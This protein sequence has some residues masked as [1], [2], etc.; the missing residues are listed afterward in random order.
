MPRWNC[1]A[2]RACAVAEWIALSRPGC[3]CSGAAS[4]PPGTRLK[5]GPASLSGRPSM[6]LAALISPAVLH[7]TC[8]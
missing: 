1:D 8:F 2:W 7:L 4:L 3:G 5:L 6:A